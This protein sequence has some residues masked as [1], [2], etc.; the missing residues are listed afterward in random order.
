MPTL[1]RPDGAS[2]FYKVV[3][4]DTGKPPLVFVHGWCSRHEHWLQQDAMAAMEV[5]HLVQPVLEIGRAH[6]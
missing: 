2:I 1:L 3:G 6:V 5:L 4:K